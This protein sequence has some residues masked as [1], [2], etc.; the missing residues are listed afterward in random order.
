MSVSVVGV[1]GAGFMGSGIAE[2]AAAAGKQVL[3]YEPDPR[4]LEHSRQR[5]AGS[6]AKAV[7]RGKLGGD[8][9]AKLVKRVVYTTE[10]EEL[11]RADAV[12]EAIVEDPK[13]KGEL[14]ARM[15]EAFP[16]ALFL[17][18]NTPDR[19]AGGLDPASRAGARTPFLLA[20]TGDEA[21]RGRNRTRH[22]RGNGHRR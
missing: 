12:I 21:R 9:G 3:V 7:D 14:F 10:L 6:V 15:D 8:D 18:S 17:A 19:R 1:V 4:P 2:T 22:R 5:L 11:R 13:I 16:D 20:L